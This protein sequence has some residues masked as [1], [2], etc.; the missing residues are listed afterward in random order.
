MKESCRIASSC[1]F[2][3]KFVYGSIGQSALDSAGIASY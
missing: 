3:Q 1:L 2:E